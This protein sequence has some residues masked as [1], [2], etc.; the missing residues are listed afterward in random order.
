MMK[1]IDKQLNNV[2]MYSLVLY[3]L[4]L[5]Y[6]AVLYLSI[7]Q[8][9]VLDTFALL[10]SL[11]L[12]LVICWLTNRAFAAVYNV[13]ANVES[14]YITALILALIISPPQ[15]GSDYWFL[16]W[17]GVLAMASKYIVAYKG[18]HLFNPA[19]FAVMLTYFATNQSASW[20]IGNTYL[21]PL[22]IIGGLLIVRKLGRFDLVISFL[23]SN[24]VFTWM[25]GWFTGDPF[26]STLRNSLAYSPILFFA[27]I[28][29]TEPLTAPPT[30]RLRINYGAL[31][32]FLLTPQLHLGALYITPELAIIIGNLYS[33][34]VSPKEKLR[35]KLK[36]KILIAPNIY[37]FI[38]A[39]P[40]KFSFKP[41]QYMEWTL[42]H[43]SP[44]N[45]GNR[46]YFT[47]ASSPTENVLRVGIKVYDTPS[48]F[49]S[50]MLAMNKGSEIIAAQLDGDFVLPDNRYK[51]LVLIAGGIG[52][53]PFRSMIKNLP[54]RNLKRSITIVYAVNDANDI[55]YKDIFDRAERELGIKTIYSISNNGTKD[56]KLHLTP[57]QVTGRLDEN[58][59]RKT[60][61]E[62]N[63]YQFYISGSRDMV[64]GVRSTLR[65]IGVANSQIK[66]D[67]FAGLS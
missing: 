59:I 31:V 47:L 20:W 11:G 2:T 56:T 48:S 4:I 46:R 21:L 17:A 43:P 40:Q 27:F 34:S 60:F 3:Y 8:A 42:G 26:L 44:D 18:K 50:S 61:P 23:I 49:K 24:L 33:Y 65:H 51:K 67:Y 62:L 6:A 53:T 12:I 35:L 64:N 25:S 19:A 36:D 58:F 22:T 45:R 54:D 30:R 63:A 57:A 37:E 7:L 15:S 32:G 1:F 41:G 66:E 13:P 55:V 14:V 10:F 39:A 28:I 29:L 52:I 5:L 16:I 38:F 9:I